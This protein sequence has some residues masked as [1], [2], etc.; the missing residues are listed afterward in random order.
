[1]VF[2]CP[3]CVR[4]RLIKPFATSQGTRSGKT[5]G[6]MVTTYLESRYVDRAKLNALLQGLFGQGCAVQVSLQSNPATRVL[7]VDAS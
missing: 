1:M 2:V 7:L 3:S 6:K 4:T 5:N